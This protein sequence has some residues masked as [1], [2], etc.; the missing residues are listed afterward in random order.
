MGQ[1]DGLRTAPP[2]GEPNNQ[3]VFVWALFLLG[4]AD[5]DIDVESVYLK[6]FELAPARLAWRTRPD[7]PDYK[8]TSKALQS[9][10]AATHVGLVQ[11]RGALARRL[12]PE[13]ARWVERHQA[14]L[15][16]TY[17]GSV[18]AAKINEHERRRRRFRA[19]SQFAAWREGHDFDLSEMA[20][21]FDCNMASPPAVWRGR[22][23]EARRAS[24]VLQDRELASFLDAVVGFLSVQVGGY[25]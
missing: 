24:D 19:S 25:A 2:S 8:K 14:V 11:K 16:A 21:V 4:G 10:E 15:E 23:N 13:G 18:A 22:M 3:D 12:T 17:S 1:N 5:R 20:D 7:L 9:V 6:S